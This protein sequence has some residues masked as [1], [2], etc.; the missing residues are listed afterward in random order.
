M[1]AIQEWPC[2]LKLFQWCNI[3]YTID[4]SVFAGQ[5]CYM[6]PYWQQ[7]EKGLCDGCLSDI[8]SG[9]YFLIRGVT[10]CFSVEYIH[11]FLFP[12]PLASARVWL[13]DDSSNHLPSIFVKC[14][15]KN[16]TKTA[17]NKEE[18]K[19][20]SQ[21]LI[22]QTEMWEGM[23][24]HFWWSHFHRSFLQM[25]LESTGVQKSPNAA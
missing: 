20:Y 15:S 11:L 7:R 3:A 8:R 22:D 6:I 18:R 1:C 16:F 2:D 13:T 12:C 21:P 23:W 4:F 25:P 10:E 19:N 17:Q 5:H 24:C 14:F 9:D